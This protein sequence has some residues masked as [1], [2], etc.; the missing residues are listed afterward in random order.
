MPLL[1][2]DPPP[3]KNSGE[4]QVYPSVFCRCGH[5]MAQTGEGLVTCLNVNCREY[6]LDYE[7]R[8][9]VAPRKARVI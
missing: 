8:V 7:V 5:F 3:V 9:T 2:P 4:F 6:G 1:R